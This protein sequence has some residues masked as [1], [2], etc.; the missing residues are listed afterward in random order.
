MNFICLQHYTLYWIDNA[1]DIRCVMNSVLAKFYEM[2]NDLGG[3]G[4]ERS[5]KK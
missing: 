1:Y 5:G 3:S 2:E 4:A